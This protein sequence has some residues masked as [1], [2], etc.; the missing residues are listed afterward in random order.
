MS[1]REAREGI[2]PKNYFIGHLIA[3]RKEKKF[4][5]MAKEVRLV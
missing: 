3:V 2:F 4:S 1:L 5:A